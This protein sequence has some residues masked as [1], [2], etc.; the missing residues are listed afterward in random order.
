MPPADEE[1]PARIVLTNVA[2][3]PEVPITTM[4]EHPSDEGWTREL[5]S[6]KLNGS[7]DL[8]VGMFRMAPHQYHPLHA[9]PNVGELYFVLE[10]R[11]ELRVGDRRELV[12]AGTAVYTPRGVAH[13]VRTQDVGV[14][15]LVTFPEGNWEKVEKVWIE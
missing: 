13:S 15:I 5:I 1:T 9:H 8:L 10:G 7:P 3:V 6:Y 2:S 12:E 4:T 11:C 14:S